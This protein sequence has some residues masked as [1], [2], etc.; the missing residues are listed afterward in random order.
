MKIEYRIVLFLL[1][2]FATFTRADEWPYDPICRSHNATSET[3]KLS[4]PKERTV[5]LCRFGVDSYIESIT[6]DKAVTFQW[7]TWAVREYANNNPEPFEG[8]SCDHLGAQIYSAEDRQG[9]L[10]ELCLFGDDSIM[11]AETFGYG[12]GSDWN[13]QMDQ[14]LGL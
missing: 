5:V 14:A 13:V 7:Q 2:G 11:E 4:Q 10:Y 12:V 1:F 8:D 9:R 6:L 3:V